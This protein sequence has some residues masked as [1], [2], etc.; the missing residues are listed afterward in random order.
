[1]KQ[2]DHIK[3]DRLRCPICSCVYGTQDVHTLFQEKMKRIVHATCPK[4]ESS[5]FLSLEANPF[6]MVGIGVPT[7]LSYGEA[8]RWA[9]KSPITTDTVISVYQDLKQY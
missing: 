3:S 1:M 2:T 8:V 5:L 9:T 6:G 7:D 4:C